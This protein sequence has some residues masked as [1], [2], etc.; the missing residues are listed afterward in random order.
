[1][2]QKP[3]FDICNNFRAVSQLLR[4]LLC[5]Q[6]VAK[7]KRC[8]K[9]NAV[10]L[11]FLKQ[12]LLGSTSTDICVLAGDWNDDQA[13]NAEDINGMLEFLLTDTTKK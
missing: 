7:V 2:S 9:V 11:A 4:I 8:K 3:V 5:K 1:M 13:L 6:L 12:T 10:D